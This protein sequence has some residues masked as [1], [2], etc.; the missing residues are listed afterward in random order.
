MAED[1]TNILEVDFSKLS[2]EPRVYFCDDRLRSVIE[3]LVGFSLESITVMNPKNASHLVAREKDSLNR[4]VQVLDDRHISLFYAGEAETPDFN[5]F[6]FAIGFD[7]LDFGDRYV[8]PHPLHRF[9]V[10]THLA[11]ECLPREL[12]SVVDRQN[13]CD[14][15]YSNGSAH[16]MR[17]RVFK[18]LQKKK[19]I[20]SWGAHLN[21]RGDRFVRLDWDSDWRAETLRLK[22]QYRFSISIENARYRGYT[23]EKI[24]A[25]ILAGSVPIYWGNHEIAQ[26]FNPKRFVNLHDYA[27][28][29]EAVEAVISLDSDHTTLTEVASMPML[30]PLQEEVYAGSRK[31]VAELFYRFLE[32]N[33]AAGKRRGEGSR[34]S[35]YLRAIKQEKSMSER[36]AVIKALRKLRLLATR[37]RTRFVSLS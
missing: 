7:P 5:L 10:Y 25:S 36:S 34:A 20:D 31:V 9:Q 15:I 12:D 8:R 30:T 17:D 6:D 22:A 35:D 13:F 11:R 4:F 1:C 21:N 33:G 18:E 29:S 27:D 26:D 14:F 28:V 2:E 32:A 23:S 24:I 19:D 37:G 3:G 16:P